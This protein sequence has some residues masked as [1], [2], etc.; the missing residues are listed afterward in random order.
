MNQDN[1]TA[2]PPVKM[3]S[4]EFEFL[5]T[6]ANYLATK[7]YIEVFQFIAKIQLTVNQ[8]EEELLLEQ[9]KDKE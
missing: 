1:K 8:N 9:K 7:P 4:L 3:I 6:L 5:Q 2:P